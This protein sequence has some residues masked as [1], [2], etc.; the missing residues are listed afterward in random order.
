[1]CMWLERHVINFCSLS[2]MIKSICAN[3]FLIECCRRLLTMSLIPIAELQMLCSRTTL[4]IEVEPE[5][6]TLN[7]I[8]L[9]TLD[10]YGHSL[11]ALISRAFQTPS[12]AQSIV[13]QRVILW[14]FQWTEP[15]LDF[16][17]KSLRPSPF[18][19]IGRVLACVCSRFMKSTKKLQQICFSTP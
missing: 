5:P 2:V 4:C 18:V 15:K 19:A 17:S 14:L 9:F 1:M 3:S 10:L 12:K 16:G 7:W 11:S 6:A 13:P 8:C